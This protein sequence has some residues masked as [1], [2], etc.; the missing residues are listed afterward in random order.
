MMNSI[1][2]YYIVGIFDVYIVINCWFI[3]VY[4]DFIFIERYKIL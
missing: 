1:K 2:S 3:D 4:V